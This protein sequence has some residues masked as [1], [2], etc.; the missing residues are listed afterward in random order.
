MS[1]TSTDSSAR[2]SRRPLRASRSARPPVAQRG[3]GPHGLARLSRRRE[4]GLREG[5]GAVQ[6]EAAG[7]RRQDARRALR[8]LSPTRSP[9]RC[10]AARGRT[11]S[12]SPRTA[13][14]AGSRPARPSSRSTSS[15]TR[16]WSRSSCP[17]TMEAMTYRRHGLR[18]AAELQGITMIY[19]TALVKTP[20]KTTGELIKVAKSLT[21]RDRPGASALPTS[22]RTSSYHAALMNA[23]GGQVF[24]P[25]P[26]ARDRLAAEHRGRQDDAAVVQEGRDPAGRPVV[27]ADREPVQRRQGRDRVLRSVVPRRGAGQGQVRDRAAADGRR[28]GWQADAALADRG[29]RLRRQRGSNHKEASYAFAEYLVSLEAA[30]V[31]AL[32]GGQR[33]PTRRSTR[34]QRWWRI[35]RCRVSASSS[36]PRCRCRTTPR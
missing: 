11:C 30:R 33:R 23:F 32:E 34:T 4:G 3:H 8:R 19:N 22:T 12:S 17:A 9:P 28:G 2:R 36:T 26:E 27:D 24:A 16:R 7:R 10:R 14:A 13:S 5:R 15:S 31:L 1:G 25:R 29:G 20:P 18:P 35:R 6:R 21:E